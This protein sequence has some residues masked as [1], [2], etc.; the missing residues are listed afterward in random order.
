MVFTKPLN[1]WMFENTVSRKE[2]KKMTLFLEI[3]K[4]CFFFVCFFFFFSQGK[5]LRKK[6][7]FFFFFF[8][9]RI[10]KEKKVNGPVKCFG[11]QPFLPSCV[12]LATIRILTILSPSAL[13]IVIQ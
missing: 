9:E 4:L 3:R 11:L 13:K 7:R 8:F 2:K 12:Q 10:K 5:K 1:V 6:E